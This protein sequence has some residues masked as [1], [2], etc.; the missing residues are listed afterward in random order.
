M[1]RLRLIAV[2]M[3]SS[4]VAA[5]AASG[6]LT[7]LSSEGGGASTGSGGATLTAT[8]TS[9]SGGFQ[10]KGTVASPLVP[11]IAQPLRLQIANPYAF[12]IYV[13]G[14]TVAVQPATSNAKCDGQT[15]LRVAQSNLAT[16]ALTV[17]VGPNGSVTL[18]A[19]STSSVTATA[20]K[21]TLLDLKSNQDSCKSARFSLRYSGSATK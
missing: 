20:P 1:G 8:S 10:L 11:G 6:M 13:G 15:N 4:L 3:I 9:G 17:R 2:G 21:V 12:A 16:T 18:P 7:R 14:V 19:A 5:G